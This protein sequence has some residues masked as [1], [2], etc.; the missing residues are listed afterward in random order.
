LDFL[1]ENITQRGG[2]GG[3]R[4]LAEKKNV[5][6][7][8]PRLP[9][10]HPGR[11]PCEKSEPRSSASNRN[12]R[13]LTM[14]FEERPPPPKGAGAPGSPTDLPPGQPARRATSKKSFPVHLLRGESIS[15]RSNF[16]YRGHRW[17]GN[18]G[19]FVFFYQIEFWPTERAPGPDSDSFRSNRKPKGGRIVMPSTK[20]TCR[21]AACC[22]HWRAGGG[23]VGPAPAIIALFRKNLLAK[24]YLVV[25]HGP[26][27]ST[28]GKALPGLENRRG[29]FRK[30]ERLFFKP[31][32]SVN[33]GTKKK[34]FSFEKPA[35]FA[36]CFSKRPPP[37]PDSVLDI[38]IN[39]WP[40]QCSDPGGGPIER[41]LS[42]FERRSG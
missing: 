7:H 41:V 32:Q 3:R 16:F 39:Q 22:G 10:G 24:G 18:F 33:M 5:D 38:L 42:L 14:G 13:D 21:P 6:P 29:P 2:G 25:G 27:W 28:A 36:R 34:E 19:G 23:G 20:P 11:C 1:E 15:W 17:G 40:D 8:R 30:G 12:T 37:R 31:S 9:R 35:G 26:P 4:G